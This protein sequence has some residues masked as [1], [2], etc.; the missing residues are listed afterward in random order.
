MILGEPE[1]VVLDLVRS[2][3][4]TALDD[5]K[6]RLVED[7]GFDSLEILL[8]LDRLEETFRIEIPD[9][10]VETGAMATVSGIVNYV[11]GRLENV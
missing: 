3:K 7:L 11:R 8:L 4:L 2:L 5:A 6:A 10:D 9:C 1:A